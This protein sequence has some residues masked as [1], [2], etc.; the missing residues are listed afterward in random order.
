MPAVR[1]RADAIDSGRL[2]GLVELSD[3]TFSYDG[4]GFL[5][6]STDPL[7]RSVT[8][9]HDADGRV[10]VETLPDGRV[11][12]AVEPAAVGSADPGRALDRG[13]GAQRVAEPERVEGV[14]RVR[15]DTEPGAE[16]GC[17]ED[18]EGFDVQKRAR[19]AIALK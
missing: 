15:G 5:A 2:T 13:A 17:G 8:F 18:C 3:V 7:G 11:G 19:G 10:T 9:T 1:D 4:N 6:G 16:Y 14:E 12:R